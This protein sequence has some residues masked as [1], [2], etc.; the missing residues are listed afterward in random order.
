MDMDKYIKANSSEWLK[1]MGRLHFTILFLPT[2]TEEKLEAAKEALNS[3]KPQILKL[4]RSQPMR[5]YLEGVYSFKF[6]TEDKEDTRVLYTRLS[7]KKVYYVYQSLINIITAKFLEAGI[8][9][10]EVLKHSGIRFDYKRKSY[11]KMSSHMTLVNCSDQRF[12][13]KQAAFN[14]DPIVKKFQNFKFGWFDLD[15]IT[16]YEFPE[17]GE[18]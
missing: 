14:G 12:G 15:E 3:C 1:K 18:S 10:E 13:D 8:I 9:D 16:I 5:M 2:D 17:P 11:A 6:K 4:L 7:G